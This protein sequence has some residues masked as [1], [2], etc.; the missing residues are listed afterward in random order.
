MRTDI[1]RPMDI[2]YNTLFQSGGY[3]YIWWY[4]LFWGLI[5]EIAAG[6]SLILSGWLAERDAH[7]MPIPFFLVSLCLDVHR[8]DENDV[9]CNLFIA[10]AG[11]EKKKSPVRN[12]FIFFRS[13]YINRNAE[14]GL[15]LPILYILCIQYLVD[16]WDRISSLCFCYSTKIPNATNKRREMRK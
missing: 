3:I 5:C 2:S 15:A 7:E 11:T 10:A 4:A 14:S 9:M 12:L 8:K 1:E 6:R 16:D 13:W